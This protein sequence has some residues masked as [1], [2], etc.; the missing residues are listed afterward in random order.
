[1]TFTIKLSVAVAIIIWLAMLP[2]LFTNGRC[3]AE[4]DAEGAQ[5]ATDAESLNS[6]VDA[7]GYYSAR[8]VPHALVSVDEC[9]HRKP[10]TLSRCGDGPVVIAK[11]PVK[12]WIC[13]TYRDDAISVI[14]QYDA[15]GRLVKQELGMQPYKTLPIPLTKGL[16]WGR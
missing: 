13:R 3:T 5:L 9:R 2:P 15:G 4:L 7:D 10:R 1:M 8:G 14:L 6:P 16:S 11:V 12:N